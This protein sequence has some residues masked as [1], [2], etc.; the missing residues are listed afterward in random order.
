MRR[1]LLRVLYGDGRRGCGPQRH[2][3]RLPLVEDDPQGVKVALGPYRL[4]YRLL[5]RHILYAAE[6]ISEIGD[7]ARFGG[8][9]NAEV[10]N[11]HVARVSDEDVTWLYVPVDHALLVGGL[12]GLGD[13]QRHS[14]HRA[15]RQGTFAHDPL[16]EG[17]AGEVLH[18]Y[19]IHSIAGLAPGK[20]GDY[21]RVGERRGTASLALEALNELLVL[22]VLILEQLEGH[23]P[24]EDLVVRKEDISHASAAYQLS[25][26][27][28]LVDER[29][30]HR[31]SQTC[32]EF[33][34]SVGCEVF[35]SFPHFFRLPFKSQS[36]GRTQSDSNTSVTIR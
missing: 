17:S 35:K 32:R 11:L 31:A 13:L 23:V 16:L 21:V 10:C 34:P 15:S 7:R 29:L 18:R 33:T 24:I 8:V 2:P 22:C 20:D 28:S 14:R 36:K 9:G 27:V 3:A 30:A 12:Q 4:A 1:G 6:D 5:G 26:F 25:K 19:V